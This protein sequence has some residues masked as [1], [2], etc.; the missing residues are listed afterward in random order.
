M[1]ADERA[2]FLAGLPH[3]TVRWLA[4]EWLFQARDEQLPPDGDWTVWLILGGRGAGKTR[5]GA[6]W[7]KGMALGRD[8]FAPAP[9]GRIALVGENLID[10]RAVMVEGVSGILAVHAADE[11]PAWQPSRRR[12]EWKNGAIAELYSADDP[13]SLRGPQFGAAWADELAKWRQ[14]EA[15][16]DMLQFALRLGERPRQ[17]V[18]T[19]PRAIPLLKR[20]IAAPGTAVARMPTR[21]NAA[22]L[23]PGF[24]EAVVGRY[25]GTRLG[26]QELDGEILTDRED[27]LWS[28]DAVERARVDA[29]PELT[30]IVVAV[31]PPAS[32][33]RASVCGIV[34]AGLGTDGLG[35]VV[36]DD[37]VTAAAPDV[38]AARA[39]A[40]WRRL[41]ADA[42]VAEINQGG[43]MVA[44]VIRQVDA[45]VPVRAVRASR[46][47]W[48]RAE[49]V[50]TLYA[51]GRVRHAGV[52]P[53]LEDELCAFGPDGQANGRSPDR[54]DALVWALTDLML[55]PGGR[56]AIRRV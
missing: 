30:R 32:G 21:D 46:G 31:D 51:Q 33:G 43:D 16:W 22:N 42:L 20:L 5:A 37:T 29:A 44:A 9:V 48:L 15:A 54:L 45:G 35:Y 53:E 52:F 14:A 1:T 2:V 12:L 49:P 24:L 40:T 10:A 18:T 41:E 23:A 36:A 7:V 27:A 6:E 25:R 47:K 11:R 26:R 34:A 28:R 3:E 4:R 8:G 13:E 39:V 55:A 38:W 50:A 19:T 17:A 56:P